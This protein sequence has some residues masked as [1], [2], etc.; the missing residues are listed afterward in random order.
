MDSWGWIASGWL[1][2]IQSGREGVT[3]NE[4]KGDAFIYKW[5]VETG[6]KMI[7]GEQRKT[8]A[9]CRDALNPIPI[10]ICTFIHQAKKKFL[11]LFF[12]IF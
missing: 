10:K 2:P 4:L 5:L 8:S 9:I 7:L 1:L 11:P 3:R 12:P 6:H